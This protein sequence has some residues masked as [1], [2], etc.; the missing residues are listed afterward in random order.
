LIYLKQARKYP[1]LPEGWFGTVPLQLRPSELPLQH[2]PLTQIPVTQA[3][4][5]LLGARR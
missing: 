5:T 4:E 1:R 3:V 2:Y